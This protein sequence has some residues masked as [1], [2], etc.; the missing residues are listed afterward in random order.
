ML[1]MTLG[2]YRIRHLNCVLLLLFYFTNFNGKYHGIGKKATS[3][4]IKAGFIHGNYD[5]S[6][7]PG[8]QLEQIISPV[9]L[10]KSVGSNRFHLS[11]E[12][13]TVRQLVYAQHLYNYISAMSL[14]KH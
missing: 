10:Y 11:Q 1:A 4:K 3:S 13:D 14:M 7:Q 6:D 5:Y 9:V 2:I 12:E 8:S